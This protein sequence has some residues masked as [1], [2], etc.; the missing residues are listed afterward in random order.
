MTSTAHSW[1]NVYFEG[2][3]PENDGK[4]QTEGV[5]T[6]AWDEMDGLKG[7]AKRGLQCVQRIEVDWEIAPPEAD[8]LEGLSEGLFSIAGGKDDG[9]EGLESGM[10]KAKIGEGVKT[11]QVEGEEDMKGGESEDEEGLRS[12]GAE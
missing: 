1:F 5:H 11:G 3:A 10:K 4:A 2:E 9:L 7:S 12:Y 6:V 8:G